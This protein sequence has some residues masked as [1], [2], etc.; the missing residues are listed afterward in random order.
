LDKTKTFT[1]MKKLFFLLALTSTLGMTALAQAQYQIVTV[2][3]SIVPGGV[4]RS[5]IIYEKEDVNAEDFTTERTD[6]RTSEQD[7]VRRQDLRAEEFEE[8]KLLNFFSMAGINFQN[9]ASNDAIITDKLNQLSAEG[10]DLVFVTSGVESY[11][12]DV[13]SNGIFITRFIFRR[14]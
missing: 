13:D 14:N 6:G 5:R 1:I 11:G 8:T 12:G 2:V 4:G 9:I 10:W 7:Q 3:E